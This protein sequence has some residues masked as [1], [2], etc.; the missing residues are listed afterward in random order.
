MH[1]SKWKHLKSGGIYDLL[2]FCRREHD[3]APCV[4]Y[5]SELHPEEIF[6]RTTADFFDGKF[7][8]IPLPR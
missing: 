2:G 3:M 7:E 4:I 1:D 6:C 8:L 5:R